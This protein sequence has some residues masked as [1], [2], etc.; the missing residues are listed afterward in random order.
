MAQRIPI[1][2]Q[3]LPKAKKAIQEI[4]KFRLY[5]GDFVQVIN[6]PHRGK[7]GPIAKIIKDQNRVVVKGVNMVRYNLIGT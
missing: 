7:Q 1:A 3:K 5:E 6:G 2:L 4:K